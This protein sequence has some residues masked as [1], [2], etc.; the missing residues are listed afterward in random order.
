MKTILTRLKETRGE[1]LVESMIAILIFTFASILFL[2]LVTSAAN[3]N[4]R[5]NEADE[6]FQA[7]QLA[8]EQAP[9]ESAQSAQAVLFKDKNGNGALD[10]GEAV[11]T[12]TMKVVAE[13]DDALYA[14]YLPTPVPAEGGT[15]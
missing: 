13:D 2:T 8:V 7:Q 15:Q 5:V 10:E 1:T 3:I 14:Y 6:S 11:V 12:A 9:T 4:I